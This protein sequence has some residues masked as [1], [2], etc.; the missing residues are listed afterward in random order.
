MPDVPNGLSKHIAPGMRFGRLEV[1]ADSSLPIL[2]GRHLSVRCDCGAEAIVAAAR[3][4]SVTGPR[5]CGCLAR[6]RPKPDRPRGGAGIERAGSPTYQCWRNMRQRCFNTACPRYPDYGGRGISVCAAWTSFD[7]FVN[8]MGSKPSGMSLDR[9]DNDGDYS[10]E[11]CR[12]ATA[13]QQ[14]RNRRVR[15]SGSRAQA[16]MRA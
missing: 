3:L 2:G 13:S 1:V 16:R 9:I 4:R 12:W 15:G 8:D 10:P 7:A 14:A 6:D 5:S 11:N